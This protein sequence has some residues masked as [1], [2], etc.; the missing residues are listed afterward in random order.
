MT[1][2]E[3]RSAIVTGASRGIGLAI[4][5]QLIAEGARVCITGRNASA[6]ATAVDLLN[7]AGSGVAIFAAGRA[8]DPQHQAEAVRRTIAEF[9]SLDVLVN[10][11]ATNPVFG[12]MIEIEASTARKIFEVNAL[13]A[14]SWIQHAYRAWMAEH[15]G[16]VVNVASIAGLR[17]SPG[18]GF[19]GASKAMLIA[20][21]RELAVELGPA[22]RVNAVAPAVVKTRFARLLYEG[23]EE[24]LSARYPLGRIGQPE[25]V[26]EAACFLASRR[27]AWITGQVLTLDGG[28]TLAAGH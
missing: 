4:A 9:G 11:A 6:L 19:Y 5:A 21:T 7:G 13:G 28:I 2:P 22:I 20:V 1:A 23:H 25:D 27:A 15:G 3:P 12:R 10:N 14:L 24:A 8:D 26:A 16:A 18:I 17:P